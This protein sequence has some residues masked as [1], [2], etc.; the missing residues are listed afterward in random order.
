MLVDMYGGDE[1][2]KDENME[3]RFPTRLPTASFP[4][5]KAAALEWLK[6]VL[7]ERLLIAKCAAEA[8]CTIEVSGPSEAIEVD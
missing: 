1:K 8:E 5:K 7:N 2:E 6:L 3:L 4:F